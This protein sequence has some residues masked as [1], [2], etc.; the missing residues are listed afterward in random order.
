[1]TGVQTCALPISKT[2]SYSVSLV[3]AVADKYTITTTGTSGKEFAIKDNTGKIIATIT[4]TGLNSAITAAGTYSANVVANGVTV[5]YHAGE[6]FGFYDKDS[7]RLAENALNK[8][9]TSSI[10]GTSVT[11]SARSDAP[12]VYDAVGNI[13]KLGQRHRGRDDGDT[14]KIEDEQMGGQP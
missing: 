8:Y 7:N 5:A 3:G 4:A 11:S 12:V 9:F 6:S 13:V 1:M 14:A 2:T 10:N